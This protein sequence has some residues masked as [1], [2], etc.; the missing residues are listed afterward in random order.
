MGKQPAS[1]TFKFW[2]TLGEQLH[3]HWDSSQVMQMSLCKIPI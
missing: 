3:I 2:F 1:E